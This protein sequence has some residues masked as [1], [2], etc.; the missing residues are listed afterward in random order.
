M[1]SYTYDDNYSTCVET[2]STLRIFSDSVLVIEMTVLLNLQPTKSFT[3][4]E[5][6]G[7]PPLTRK[8]N[9][10]FLATKN[11]LQS[12]DTRRHLDHIID[13]IEPRRDALQKLIELGC[14]IDICS[15][16]LSVGHGGLK[17]EHEQM[18]RLAELKISVWWDLY[19]SERNDEAR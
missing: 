3:K 9:G 6:F 1:Q 18:K 17:I 5:I 14:E 8:A 10:W 12:R 11:S 19:V 4:G 15:F 16:W 7:K 13:S 2:H